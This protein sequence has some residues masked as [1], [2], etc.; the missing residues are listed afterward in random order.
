MADEPKIDTGISLTSEMLEAILTA[1]MNKAGTENVEAFQKRTAE[2]HE[3]NFVNINPEEY[4]AILDMSLMRVDT[5]D[6]CN[7]Y[8][9]LSA[10][11]YLDMFPAEDR[12][13]VNT[14]FST[15]QGLRKIYR[16]KMFINEVMDT[17]IFQYRIVPTPKGMNLNVPTISPMNSIELRMRRGDE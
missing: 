5:W 12:T 9:E 8:F 13:K 11:Q 17:D 1:A 4:I 15:K 16:F 10:Q 2:A 6:G 3:D 7:G 14:I